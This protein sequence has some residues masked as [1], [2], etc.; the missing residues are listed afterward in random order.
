MTA[1]RSGTPGDATAIA[2]VHVAAWRET[3]PGI[4]PESVIATKTVG[5][6]ETQWRQWLATPH[7]SVFVAERDA[8]IV[9]FAACGARRDPPDVALGE[10]FAIYLLRSHQG[11][12]LGRALFAAVDRD[13]KRRGLHPYL[14]WVVD[15]NPATAFYERV[16]GRRFLTQ[17]AD[18]F[19]SSIVEHGYIW[20]D[21]APG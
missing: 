17:R 9:G 3:Y 21:E 2:R 13:L 18:I 15:G 5:D 4:M 1:V 19:G 7:L 6:R 20:S 14:C 10:V 8:D 16:G 12:G 11:R